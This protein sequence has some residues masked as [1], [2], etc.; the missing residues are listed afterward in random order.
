MNHWNEIV[1]N[2][3]KLLISVFSGLVVIS[4]ILLWVIWPGP[5]LRFQHNLYYGDLI[6]SG[7]V[8]RGYFSDRLPRASEIRFVF[9]GDDFS[10][11]GI[12]FL[13]E[14]LQFEVFQDSVQSLEE[15]GWEIG[16]KNAPE[17]TAS[18]E[19]SWGLIYAKWIEGK[20]VGVTLHIISDDAPIMMRVGSLNKKEGVELPCSFEQVMAV[21]G[22]SDRMRDYLLH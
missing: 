7:I 6:V 5:I 10:Q 9:D 17:I 20:I 21:F 13:G 11:G 8:K 15:K 14:G 4:A 18:K 2:K 16:R 1:M 22:E 19:G 12:S 3:L